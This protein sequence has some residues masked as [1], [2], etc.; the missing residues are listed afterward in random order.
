[1]TDT[2][3]QMIDKIIDVHGSGIDA[4]WEITSK[5]DYT[6]ICNA[7]HR[8][9]ENG[10]YAGWYDFMIVIPHIQPTAWVLSVASNDEENLN[11]I[12]T[13]LADYLYDVFSCVLE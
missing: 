5:G 4:S 6:E 3:E 7:Y 2:I 13:D 1:M 10:Y 12:E 9:D 11:I 8:M